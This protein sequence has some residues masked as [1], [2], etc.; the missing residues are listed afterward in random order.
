MVNSIAPAYVQIEYHSLYAPHV[1]KIPIRGIENPTAPPL[2]LSAEA[3]DTTSVVIDTMVDNLVTELVP[4][5]PATASFD[6]WTVWSQ[7]TPEDEPL[8]V[9]GASINSVG[10]AAV[11][12]WS[13]ATQET[14]SMRDTG[15]NLVKV[16][17]MDFASGD[18][19]EAYTS[20][21]AIGVDGIIGEFFSSS[22]AW[23][24]R[25][26]LQPSSFVRRTATLNEALRR[27]YRMG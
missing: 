17:L 15:G 8:F 9:G 27:A 25:A 13:K 16:T 6:R 10:T 19:F 22:N 3:W 23:M 24:S 14:V 12:G 4:R 5:F 2:S 1:M 20:A 21:A 26:N 11:P 18:D 7:P